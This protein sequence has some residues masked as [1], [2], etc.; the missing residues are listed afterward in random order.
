MEGPSLYLAKQ[1]LAPFR[2]QTVRSVSG[3]TKTD[4]ERLAGKK[5]KDIFSWGKHLVF[6]F[7]TFAVRIH[8][9]LYGTFAATVDGMSVTG[10][11]RKGRVPRLELRFDNGTIE[12]FN[13]SV[14]FI[15]EHNL[16][17]RY[18]YSIDIMSS[19]W[20]Q[21]AALKNVRMHGGDQICDVLLDQTIFS[22]VGNI[23]KNEV[24]SIVKLNPRTA[25]E[26]IPVR[27]LNALIDEARS[28]SRQFYR[29]R[30][31]FK[32]KANLKV[33]RKPMCPHCS[34]KIARRWTGARNR[35]SFWCPICQPEPK[36]DLSA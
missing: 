2:K 8:F 24:L 18:D 15:E 20:D 35:I 32:L 4:K 9:M 27:Q 29:W 14:K 6:Q 11:Y 21:G 30:K 19:K 34:G 23:I 13:C 33:Y 7:D 17:S 36:S 28:F 16:K 31:A 26:D 10:D 25:V 3:N 22:G 12:M 1:Q 5:V